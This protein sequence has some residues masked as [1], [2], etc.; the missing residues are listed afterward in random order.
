MGTG[1]I[2]DTA[3]IYFDARLSESYPTVEIRVA[4]VCLDADSATLL[5]ALAR[6]LVETAAR[7]ATDGHVAPMLHPS[8]CA[9][10]RGGPGARASAA[11]WSRRSRGSPPRPTTS[12][13]SSSRTCARRSST[14][15]TWTP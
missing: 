10:R 11:T 2:L 9:P 5:A 6:G 12:S 3:M 13:A 14:R 7:E 1:T 8:S 4:D 15:A